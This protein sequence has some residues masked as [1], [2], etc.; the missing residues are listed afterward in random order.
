L[1]INRHYSISQVY[2][3]TVSGASKQF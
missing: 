1:K 3:S 2:N